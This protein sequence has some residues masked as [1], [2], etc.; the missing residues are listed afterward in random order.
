MPDLQQYLD[1]KHPPSVRARQDLE[2]RII[3]E[4]AKHLIGHGFVLRVFD[5]EEYVTK[6]TSDMKAIHEAIM[7]T[8]EDHLF[9]YPVNEEQ[10]IGWIHFVYGNDGFDVAS[11]WTD[12]LSR[13][14]QPILDKY[15]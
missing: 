13:H 6:R 2:R 1:P 5:G 3:D 7:S 9:V 4:I 15:T 14:I 11:N 8:D 10:A 12:T